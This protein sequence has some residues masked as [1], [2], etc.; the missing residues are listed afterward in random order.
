MKETCTTYG[1]IELLCNL[2]VSL[3][4]VKDGSSRQGGNKMVVNA[5]LSQYMNDVL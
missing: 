3:P 4:S 2:L 1:E 5:K